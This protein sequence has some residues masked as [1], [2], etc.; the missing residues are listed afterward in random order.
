MSTCICKGFYCPP[1][2]PVHGRNAVQPVASKSD[3]WIA[4]LLATPKR[5]QGKSHASHRHAPK[6][7]KEL[8]IRLGAETTRG[9]GSGNDRGDVRKK[10]VC[11]IEC[12]ST[13]HKSFSLT[14]EMLDKIEEAGMS[15]S[16][17]PCMQIDFV[18]KNS[19]KVKHSVA[20]LPVWVLEMMF[21]G[22]Q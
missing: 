2:C 20:V 6:Q 7:E 11:R 21:G 1:N 15:H 19:G 5:E 22:I 14:T 9:S 17:I 10:R 12:K 8:A 3:K 13:I 16:E 4:G 18:G